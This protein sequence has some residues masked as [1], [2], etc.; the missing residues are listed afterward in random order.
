MST[1]SPFGSVSHFTNIGSWKAG[2]PT[3]NPPK[4]SIKSNRN[5]TVTG[6]SCL[7]RATAANFGYRIL[8]VKNHSNPSLIHNSNI[9]NDVPA[10]LWLHELNV[11]ATKNSGNGFLQQTCRTN[12]LAAVHDILWT[13]AAERL[14]A[15]FPTHC[16]RKLNL[17]NCS[18]L[19][20]F[21][22]M[23]TWGQLLQDATTNGLGD[24]KPQSLIETSLWRAWVA[25]I[26]RWEQI[27][28]QKIY[29]E[30]SFEIIT[31]SIWSILIHS[32]NIDPDN[33]AGLWLHELNVFSTKNS[34]NGFLKQTCR[35]NLLSAVHDILW[36]SAAERLAAPF[37]THCGRK[38]NLDNCSL[39]RGFCYMET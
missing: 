22:Y 13:S 23:E 25:W 10:G 20:G 1:K 39:L 27:W 7:D 8:T 32:S 11:F 17:D 31:D 3:S 21:C 28:V 34:G 14:A 24:H 15:P 19:R 30:R 4:R 38:L 36:T 6:M 5:F 35:T 33:R 29:G 2:S 12:L 18:L 26:E 16:G 9:D 37:P